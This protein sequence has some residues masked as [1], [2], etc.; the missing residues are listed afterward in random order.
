MVWLDARYNIVMTRMASGTGYEI[1]LREPNKSRRQPRVRDR[2]NIQRHNCRVYLMVCTGPSFV[3][4]VHVYTR[5]SGLTLKPCFAH[6]HSTTQ[7]IVQRR[8]AFAWICV[9][10]DVCANDLRPPSP[11]AFALR[12]SP[13]TT[14]YQHGHLR[15]SLAQSPWDRD[16]PRVIFSLHC[17]MAQC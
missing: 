4:H 7:L 17:P 10:S 13:A 9:S 3:M 1:V 5:P 15:I 12:C 11:L 6:A 8:G 16:N 2:I 14:S